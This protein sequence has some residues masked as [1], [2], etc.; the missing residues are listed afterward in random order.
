MQITIQNLP[1][2]GYIVF[3]DANADWQTGMARMPTFAASKLKHVLE[4]IEGQFNA[5]TV[6]IDSPSM[7]AR[8]RRRMRGISSGNSPDI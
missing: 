6:P 2:G 1:D 8:Q 7:T 3:K 5:V 4:Y